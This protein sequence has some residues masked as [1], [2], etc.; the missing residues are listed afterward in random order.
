MALPDMF[1]FINGRR[2]KE[3]GEDTAVEFIQS[4]ATVMLFNFATY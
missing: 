4:A 2:R 3:V 1:K